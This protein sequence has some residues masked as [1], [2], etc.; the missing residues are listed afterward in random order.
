MES[1]NQVLD[2]L[3]ETWETDLPNETD[4]STIM[5]VIG[6]R[7][8]KEQNEIAEKEQEDKVEAPKINGVI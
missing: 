4:V 1:K 6:D 7:L 2:F 5:T 3:R 8:Y